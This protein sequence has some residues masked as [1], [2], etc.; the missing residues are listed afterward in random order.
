[1][2]RSGEKSVLGIILAALLCWYSIAAAQDKAPQDIVVK[3]NPIEPSDPIVAKAK[4]AF[5]GNCL[6]CHGA[7]GKGDGPMSG[8]LKEKPADLTNPSLLS[9]LTDG[10]IFW[11]LSK[12]KQPV[13][14]AFESKLTPEERWS[15]VHFLRGMSK[16]QPNSDP[17][18]A[19]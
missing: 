10:Q 17:K 2:R 8:M 13:M 19:H 11:I 5:E 9:A 12:G 4:D 1:M 18:K 7:S 3:K 14:P 15:L 6:Q 16:T